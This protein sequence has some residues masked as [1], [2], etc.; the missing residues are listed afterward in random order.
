M[1]TIRAYGARHYRVRKSLPVHVAN[2]PLRIAITGAVPGGAVNGVLE[3]GASTNEPVGRVTL[4][5]DG[6]PV[7]RDASRPY[8]LSWNTSG[9]PEGQHTLLV[10]ARGTR[11][12]ALTLPVVVANAPQFPASLRAVES[13]GVVTPER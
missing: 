3:L 4:Y 5:A 11:R 13:F 12:A 9:V 2:P 8:R 6:K 10:Y 7:S 1:L